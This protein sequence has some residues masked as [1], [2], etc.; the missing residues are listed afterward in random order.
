[1]LQAV[2]KQLGLK[3]TLLERFLPLHLKLYL[4]A[5]QNYRTGEFKYRLAINV[6]SINKLLA[7]DIEH[8]IS[9]IS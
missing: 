3:Q 9:I 6:F 1:M 5:Y 8:G 2:M 4:I 7:V